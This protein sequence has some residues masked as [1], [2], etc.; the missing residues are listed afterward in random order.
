MHLVQLDSANYA[1]QFARQG[2]ELDLGA[3]GKGY[4]IEAAVEI[5]RDAGVQNAL[6]HG[7]TSTVYAL[8]SQPNGRPWQI[9]FAAPLG[10]PPCPLQDQ[11]LSV[12]APSSLPIKS[13]DHSSGLGDDITFR[14]AQWSPSRAPKR[15]GAGGDRSG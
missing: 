9:A 2:V 14:A 15:L 4:A 13:S 8:G 1:V 3:V 7:G 11:A 6:I 12:S 5:L 10:L